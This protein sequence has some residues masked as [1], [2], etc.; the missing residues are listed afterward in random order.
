M[1]TRDETS[2]GELLDQAIREGRFPS[3]S[4]PP[5]GSNADWDSLLSGMD[6]ERALIN[7]QGSELR[8]RR[9]EAA[10]QTLEH[11]ASLRS[12]R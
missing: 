2:T 9:D 3:F 4:I 8:R 12:S 11:F 7:G 5:F 6:V 1:T 10:A